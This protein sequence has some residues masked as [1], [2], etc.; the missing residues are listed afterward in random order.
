MKYK[1]VLELVCDAPD[2][3]EAGNIVGEFLKGDIE[4]GV[5][6]RC[7]TVSLMAHKMKK[8]AVCCAAFALLFSSLL[9]KVTPLGGEEKI[10]N[11]AGMEFS[12]Y[13]VMPELKTKHK[14]DFKK[15]WIKKKEEAVLEYLKK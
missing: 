5:E 8:Y 3:E 1:T 9:L 15:E 2:V 4:F 12:R 7:K 14:S 13:T 10:R 11:S 6:M